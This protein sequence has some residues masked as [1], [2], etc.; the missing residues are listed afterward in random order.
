MGLKVGCSGRSREGTSP[1][2]AVGC[3]SSDDSEVKVG[4]SG[5]YPPPTEPLRSLGGDG[6]RGETL[7]S[8]TAVYGKPSLG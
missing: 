3:G 4:T 7:S 2:D 6:S 1:S 5:K 8:W